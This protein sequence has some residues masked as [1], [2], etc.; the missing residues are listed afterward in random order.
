MSRFTDYDEYLRTQASNKK[1]LQDEIR[2][3][4][5]KSR[6]SMDVWIDETFSLVK[7]YIETILLP[8]RDFLMILKKRESLE[9][10]ELYNNDEPYF[11][12]RI[13]LIPRE[14]LPGAFD[15][16]DVV[17]KN[18]FTLNEITLHD[19]HFD[20][21]MQ[22]D[23]S[24]FDTFDRNNK[25]VTGNLEPRLFLRTW[26]KLPDEQSM[27]VNPHLTI[28]YLKKWKLTYTEIII[29]GNMRDLPGDLENT[30]LM[31][32]PRVLAHLEEVW[33]IKNY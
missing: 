32:T 20:V 15:P 16:S 2:E 5:K 7:E 14:I 33:K 30:L 29:R 18:H 9:N 31:L 3:K 4:L 22:F 27:L 19:W 8:R 10:I 23:L 1:T 17:E 12:Y 28:D 6:K 13:N 26:G 11:I 25:I 24:L 21:S